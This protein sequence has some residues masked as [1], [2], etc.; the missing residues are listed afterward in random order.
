MG[1]L[2][3]KRPVV[4]HFLDASDAGLRN[5]RKHEALGET[6][7]VRSGQV[8]CPDQCATREVVLERED[9]GALLEALG[10]DAVADVRL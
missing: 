1:Q 8:P 4:G 7:L 5:P 3:L 9:P 6:A 10:S 2:A